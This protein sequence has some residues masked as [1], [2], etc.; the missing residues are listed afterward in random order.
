MNKK[1]RSWMDLNGHRVS[2][3]MSGLL[4]PTGV[5]AV[6]DGNI[7]I[8]IFVIVVSVMNYHTGKRDEYQR[9]VYFFLTH[10]Q[11]LIEKDLVGAKNPQALSTAMDALIKG[12]NNA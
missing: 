9:S 4:V 10:F 8:C 6:I 1:K 7:L 3:F 11:E 2:F 12:K 5:S